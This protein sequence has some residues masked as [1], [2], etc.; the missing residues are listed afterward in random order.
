MRLTHL[1][2]LV[3]LTL[4]VIQGKPSTAAMP[5]I[6]PPTSQHSSQL[7]SNTASADVRQSASD[8]LGIDSGFWRT[9]Y[10][11][12]PAEQD[13]TTN[14]NPIASSTETHSG[15]PQFE[16]ANLA[17]DRTPDSIVSGD[18]MVIGPVEILV[19][20]GHAEIQAARKPDELPATN[21]S[22]WDYAVLKS[23]GS[24]TVGFTKSG[25]SMTSAIV[26]F[27]GIIIVIGAYVSSGSRR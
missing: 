4:M 27:V 10:T 21:L 5:Q 6:D 11:A 18:N 13:P 15:T 19:T 17:T 25:P 7:T 26:G 22:D 2:L 24:A 3:G 14:D 1:L 20:I 12:R 9:E 23:S 8:P 16:A